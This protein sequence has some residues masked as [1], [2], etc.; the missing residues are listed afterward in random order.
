MTS[1]QGFARRVLR[2]EVPVFRGLAALCG[3]GLSRA[4]C[5]FCYFPEPAISQGFRFGF[6][7]SGLTT[8][9]AVNPTAKTRNPIP[10]ICGVSRDP[11]PPNQADA[12][13]VASKQVCKA[14]RTANPNELP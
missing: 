14:G 5:G 11:A 4:L 10:E 12:T 8:L 9:L 6:R 3:L 2:F 1:K 7:V 13:Q